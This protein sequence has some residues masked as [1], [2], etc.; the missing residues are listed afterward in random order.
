MRQQY[1][2]RL[3]GA[4]KLIW[5]VNKIVAAAEQLPV[6]DVLLNEIAE[7]DIPYWY[8]ENGQ[9]PTCRSV[10][11]HAKLINETDLVYP[12]ILCP[13]GRVIDG[14]HRVC[15]A[16]IEGH[17]TI[18]ARKFIHMPPPDYTNVDLDDLPYDSAPVTL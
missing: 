2:Q 10:A 9:E 13:E 16:L 18:K 1:H 11:I 14:M 6:Q 17:Q 3:A 8:D 15:K 4:D 5:N 12:I 7:L